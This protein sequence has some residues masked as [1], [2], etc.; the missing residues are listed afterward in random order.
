MKRHTMNFEST[1]FERD[2]GK[3]RLVSAL[4]RKKILETNPNYESKISKMTKDELEDFD[5]ILALTEQILL[6]HHGKKEAYALLAEFVDMMKNWTVSIGDVNDQI[7]ELLISAKSSVS[8]IE[9]AKTE[10][11]NNLSFGEEK[12]G[13]INL[14][15]FVNDVNTQEYQGKS[16]LQFEQVV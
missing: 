10:V 5:S 3:I 12:Q 15:K 9:T 7:Q 16:Q 8:E 13:T 11:S 6:K 4:V 14:T 2:L 1:H